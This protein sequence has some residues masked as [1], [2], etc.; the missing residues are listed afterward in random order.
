MK[1]IFLDIEKDD[2]VQL[3]IR[4]E[5]L[6]VKRADG[7]GVDKQVFL[8]G[9]GTGQYQLTYDDS[10]GLCRFYRKRSEDSDDWT[11]PRFVHEVSI[12]EKGASKEAL[13]L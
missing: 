13:F 7:N 10:E 12:A 5:P 9:I 1:E 2:H 6:Y 11:S 8:T 3:D 4:T